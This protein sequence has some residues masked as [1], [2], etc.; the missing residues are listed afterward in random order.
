ML[1][2]GCHL[3]VAHGFLAMGKDALEI[4]PIH[5]SFS[6]V[7]REAGALKPLTKKMLPVFFKMQQNVP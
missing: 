7:I 6:L 5:F 4:K 1:K 2:I 3:S